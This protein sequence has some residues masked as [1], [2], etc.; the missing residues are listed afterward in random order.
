[1]TD[2][3][4]DHHTRES[5]HDHDLILAEHRMVNDRGGRT[6]SATRATYVLETESSAS[7]VSGSQPES[8]DF[9]QADENRPT[10]ELSQERVSSFSD[11]ALQDGDRSVLP[12]SASD[13]HTLT[14]SLDKESGALAA[15]LHALTTSNGLSSPSGSTKALSDA[16]TSKHTPRTY[17][18][19]WCD[20][21][22]EL[23]QMQIVYT[24]LH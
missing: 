22:P 17:T 12:T 11:A 13:D 6:R 20:V 4:T 23:T 18:Y 21:T 14:V 2:T 8:S 15:N 19:L 9:S 24:I 5:E 3:P 16:D 7:N 1:M 10:R